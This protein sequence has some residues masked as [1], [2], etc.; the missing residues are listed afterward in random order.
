M[1]TFRELKKILSCD[2]KLT[3]NTGC[4]YEY[5]T[6]AD[7]FDNEIYNAFNDCIVESVDIYTDAPENN[8]V[9]LHM[10]YQDDETGLYYDTVTGE[11]LPDHIQKEVSENDK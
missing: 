5:F 11:I 9:I 7:L 2:Y 10:L 3:I 6:A 4:D 1:I 8:E